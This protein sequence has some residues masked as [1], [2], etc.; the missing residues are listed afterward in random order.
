MTAVINP[1]KSLASDAAFMEVAN[2][3]AL[4]S[5]STRLEAHPSF[6][7]IWS[8]LKEDTCRS[9]CMTMQESFVKME[10]MFI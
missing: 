3:R 9:P 5:N 8:L 6:Q 2:L 7:I 1:Q 4:V 10:R